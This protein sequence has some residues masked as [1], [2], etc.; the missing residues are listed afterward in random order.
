V[1]AAEAL[2]GVLAAIAGVSGVALLAIAASTGGVDTLVLGLTALAVAAVGVAQR[3]RHHPRPFVVLLV[4]SIGCAASV[5]LLATGAAMALLPTLALMTFIGVLSLCRR[6]ALWFAMW[7]GVI[8]GFILFTH[9][10]D[11]T[12]PEG[13]TA[14]L[15][16]AGTGAA[17]WWLLTTAADTLTR[18]VEN[19]RLLID[20]SPV[21]ILEED[22]TAVA[23]WLDD[24]RSAGVD[25][26]RGHL[27]ADPEE[28]RHGISLIAVRRV[29]SA[30][31]R[32]LGAAS[33]DELEASLRS[34]YRDGGRL[35]SFVEQFVAVA[36]DRR[37]LVLDVSGVTYEG[38]PL[39]AVM[40][41]SV[42]ASNGR[43][44]LSRVI[45]AVSDVT[46]SRMIQEQ[47]AAAVE[48]NERLLIFEQALA[49]CSRTLLL[50]VGEDAVEV[51]LETLRQA[52]G[53]DRAFLAINVEDE[54]HGP[55]FHV[56]NSASKPE[57]RQDDWVG[58][59]VPW[60]RYPMASEPL[61]AGE[62]FMHQAAERP[63]EGWS[64]SLLGV[65]VVIAGA[66][67]GTVGF[68]DIA[69]RT[70]WSA[71]AVR[72]LQ[73]AA[74]ML[75]T[76]WERERTRERLE[77]LVRSKDRFV[78]S[79]SHELRTPLSAVLGF[80]EEL[81]NQAGTIQPHE[82]GEILE[83][84]AEQSRDMA[85]MV[86]DL[87][88]AARAD[89]GT[90]AIHP[91]EVYLRAQ[92]EAAVVALGGTGATSVSVVGGPGLVWADPTRTRQIVR[93]LLTNALRYGGTEVVIEARSD[94][95]VTVLSVRDDGVG[96]PQSEWT[97][98]FEPYQRAH[99]RPT[100]PASIGL[101]LTVSRQ[102]ARAMGGDLTYRASET[103]SVFE[104]TLPCGP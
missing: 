18:E 19:N 67:S 13:A 75:G 86:E 66:W 95:A 2:T 59:V 12:V 34:R 3:I 39:E 64:R 79:I 92:A 14:L 77:D 9:L 62:P 102:L 81:T 89:I 78:A 53:A 73:V 43:P 45:V 70:E 35:V 44:D 88:L 31:L 80:A 96:L 29:N 49:A 41:W 56:V 61:S 23:R 36:E 28:V 51:A 1:I 37:D 87:L 60:S 40:H 38:Q 99:D 52:I 83:L 57:Y 22:F 68:I 90:I 104:L 85:D 72:M 65:P 30:A 26:V 33:S 8:A 94:D 48:S 103:G 63:G 98:I 91:Q 55:S 4:A 97:R 71:D 93:N 101:G 5:P 42:P 47:L 54:E 69:R 15:L 11:M 10:P 16:I 7:C 6:C 32:L 20:S 50:G 100:Q 24:L 58:L 27:S 84:I 74:P 46:S 76:F 17:G 82:A 21:A 25:D